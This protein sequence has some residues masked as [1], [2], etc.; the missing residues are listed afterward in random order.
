M[1]TSSLRTVFGEAAIWLGVGAIFVLGIIFQDDLTRMVS[2]AMGTASREPAAV[3]QRPAAK[4]PVSAGG[5]KR[6]ATLSAGLHGHFFT[7]AYINGRQAKVMVDTGASIV[8]LTYDA[9]RDI[10][11][12]LSS[13]KFTHAIRTANGIAR[14]APIMLDA[15]RVGD[16]EVRNV[17]AVVAERGRLHV[18]LLGMSFLGKLSNVSIRS[19]QLILEE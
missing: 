3:T 13:S 19:G 14:V 11:F 5:F 2:G 15:V 9:A 4:A 8:A 10:G 7:T 1:M 17:R 12:Y 6:V 16:I 18:S